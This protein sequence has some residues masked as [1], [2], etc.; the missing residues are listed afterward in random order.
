MSEPVQYKVEL[1]GENRYRIFKRVP[2][3]FGFMRW[4]YV[5]WELSLPVAEHTIRRH[6]EH[7][8]E[9]PKFPKFYSSED[10]Q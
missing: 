4:K 6:I 1:K 3:L 7:D 9:I 5:D 8:L 10:F 2:G